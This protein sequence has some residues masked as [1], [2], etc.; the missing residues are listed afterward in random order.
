MCRIFVLLCHGF[1]EDESKCA[2]PSNGEVRFYCN[3]KGVLYYNEALENYEK[4]IG[5]AK[6]KQ[7]LGAGASIYNYKYEEAPDRDLYMKAGLH[8]FVVTKGGRI[9]H[10]RVPEICLTNLDDILKG[11]SRICVQ[12]NFILH[13]LTCREFK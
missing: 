5:Q 12:S 4:V 3:D 6:P 1:R 11:L 7:V 13:V 2:V 9:S 8:E 10:Q